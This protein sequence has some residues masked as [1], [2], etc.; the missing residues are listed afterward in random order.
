MGSDFG[1]KLVLL[2]LLAIIISIMKESNKCLLLLLIASS[3]SSSNTE[4]VI[5]KFP[6]PNN[7]DGTYWRNYGVETLKERLALQPNTKKAKNVI[8]FIGDGMGVATHTAARIYKGQK[9]GQSG[10]EE[11][12]EWEKFPYSGQS[13]TYNT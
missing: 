4:D 8:L 9:N 5:L 1:R 12:L 10:E 2:N 11:I 7:E 3:L 13:K 6:S